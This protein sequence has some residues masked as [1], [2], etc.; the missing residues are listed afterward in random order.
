MSDE[1]ERQEVEEAARRYAV[2]QAAR[3]IAVLRVMDMSTPGALGPH[4]GVAIRACWPSLGVQPRLRA[5]VAVQREGAWCFLSLS[6]I[7][8]AQVAGETASMSEQGPRNG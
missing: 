4:Y 3:K 7:W 8:L 1:R 2:G 5:F 6:G